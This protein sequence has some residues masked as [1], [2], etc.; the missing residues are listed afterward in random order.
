MTASIYNQRVEL[1]AEIQALDTEIRAAAHWDHDELL[2]SERPLPPDSLMRFS[3]PLRRKLA[4]DWSRQRHCRP[5]CETC[6]F[7]KDRQARMERARQALLE[8]DRKIVSGA[9]KRARGGKKPTITLESYL[10]ARSATRTG[11]DGEVARR[12]GVTRQA[13]QRWR[14]KN[15]A[16]L[17][18]DN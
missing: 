9:E 8:I 10:E 17:K 2:P 6:A 18:N 15:S 12:L 5:D 11:S 4:E 16:L 1:L 7:L 14:T 13:V 3:R